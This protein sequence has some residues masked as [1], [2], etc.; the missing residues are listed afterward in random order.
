[1]LTSSFAQLHRVLSSTSNQHIM[2]DEREEAQQE[3]A[4]GMEDALSV[5]DSYYEMVI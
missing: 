2:S 1:M 3:L 4:S 5:S